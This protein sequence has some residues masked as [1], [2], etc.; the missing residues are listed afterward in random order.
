MTTDLSAA[1]ALLSSLGVPSRLDLLATVARRQAEGA[2]CALPA[3]ATAVGR[4]QRDLAKDLSHLTDCGVLS[5]RGG[6]VT[7]DLTPLRTAADTLDE[8]H[9]V[10]PLLADDPDLARLFRHGRLV[11]VPESDELW[12]RIGRLAVRLLPVDVDLPEPEVNRL[13]GQLHPD[14]AT[15]RRLLV[16]MRLVTR[17]G[18]DAYR[19]LPEQ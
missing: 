2:D 15:L 7:A 1:A 8:V 11:T 17:H 10:T 16:D 14:H 3:V 19:R 6:V 5:V 9:P 13:L 4:S 18:S 12:H